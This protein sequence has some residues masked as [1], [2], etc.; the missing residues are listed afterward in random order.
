M[1]EYNENSSDFDP[2][3]D[4]DLNDKYI[5]FNNI[6]NIIY[7]NQIDMPTNQIFNF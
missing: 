1:E 7:P 3:K 6:K 4:L 2:F 5:I